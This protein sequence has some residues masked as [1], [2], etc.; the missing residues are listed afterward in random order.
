MPH[1]R[2]DAPRPE[3][4]RDSTCPLR[5]WDSRLEVPALEQ[6]FPFP[7]DPFQHEAIDASTKGIP[8]CQGSHGVR[9]T[10]VAKNTPSHRAWPTARRCFYTNAVKPLQPDKLRDFREQFVPIKS[11]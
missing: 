7:L 10:L 5:A 3:A 9:Q 1:C 2:S 11:A 6:L 8:W 4:G